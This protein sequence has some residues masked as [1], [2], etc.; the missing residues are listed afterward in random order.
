MA[1]QNIEKQRLMTKFLLT[2]PNEISW[3]Y[4]KFKTRRK[5]T[6]QN[7]SLFK[8]H[9]FISTSSSSISAMRFMADIFLRNIHCFW[10]SRL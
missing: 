2:H 9:I 4:I 7:L 1:Y 3:N 5:S 10:V 6:I 8:S